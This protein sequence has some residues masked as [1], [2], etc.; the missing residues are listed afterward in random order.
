[1]KRH[2]DHDHRGQGLDLG[3]YL[4]VDL[5]ICQAVA[6]GDPELCNGLSVC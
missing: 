2:H 1:M 4:S 3:V 6:K 5:S